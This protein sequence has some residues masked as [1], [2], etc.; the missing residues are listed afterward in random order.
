MRQGYSVA[1]GLL[2]SVR[3]R[4]VKDQARVVTIPNEACPLGVLQMSGTQKQSRA[5]R[6]TKLSNPFH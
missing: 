1:G 6:R 2:Q 3:A 5:G 4:V